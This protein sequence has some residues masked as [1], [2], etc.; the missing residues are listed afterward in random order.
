MWSRKK[1]AVKYC[2]W[3]AHASNALS[4]LQRYSDAKSYDLLGDVND[5]KTRTDVL[6]KNDGHRSYRWRNR[7][8]SCQ[9]TSANRH[10]IARSSDL[11][12]F[13][14]LWSCVFCGTFA[15]IC[16]LPN[17]I[18][19]PC[20]KCGSQ[21]VLHPAARCSVQNWGDGNNRLQGLV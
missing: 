6:T 9:V 7:I 19:L 2:S 11:M 18:K 8:E 21:G 14:M 17:Y 4:Y 5:C 3:T 15:Y 13:E 10:L 1:G 12:W 16:H 20:V